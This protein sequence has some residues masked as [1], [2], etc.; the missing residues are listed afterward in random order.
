MPV[1]GSHGVPATGVS[2][3]VLNVTVT[4]GTGSGYLTVY[5][6]NRK[7]PSTSNLNWVP[8]QTVAN[9]VNVDT[10]TGRLVFYNGSGATVHVIAD[11]AGY[12][13][14]TAPDAFLAQGP[15]RVLDTRI[16]SGVTPIAPG[17]SVTLSGNPD[18]AHAMVLNLTVT[19]TR[20]SG[21][22]TAY[23]TGRP[24][25]TASNLN[26]TAGRTVANLAVI[27]VG[28]GITFTNHSAGTIDLVIDEYGLYGST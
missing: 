10:G 13:S 16:G 2:S 27:Q 18:G 5:P 22:L 11:L 7:R 25:P 15:Y 12:H 28:D 24:E 23:P 4:G 20:A 17:G 6:D 1:N 3:V 8:G 21:Y 14:L 9:L 26:W 19:H